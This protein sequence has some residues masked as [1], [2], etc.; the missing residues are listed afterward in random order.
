M[1]FSRYWGVFVDGFIKFG[2]PVVSWYHSMGENVFLN[3]MAEDAQGIE[4]VANCA[5]APFQYVFA[6]HTA[7]KVEEISHNGSVGEIFYKIEQRFDY[8]DDQMWFKTGVCALSLPITLPLGVFLKSLAYLSE[9]VRERHD[10]IIASSLS[11]KVNPHARYYH[12]IGLLTD[13][14]EELNSEIYAR[15]P[16]DENNMKVDKEALKEI[17]RLL[18]ENEIPFW[19]DCGT[20]L[21][22]YRYRGIIPWDFD[23]DIAVLQMDHQNVKHALNA[24]DSDKYQLQDWSSRDKPG[25]YLRLYVKETRNVIDIYHF[26][27]DP[28]TQMMRSICSNIDSAFLPES[29]KTR[30]RRFTIPTPMSDVFPLGKATFD[31]I[32]VFVPNRTKE[33]LQARYGEDISPAKVYDERTGAYEK[34]P[35]HCYW[36]QA[37]AH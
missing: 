2:L 13:G 22:A 32:E 35:G 31:G 30:E 27:I 14:L 9:D 10:L 34:V 11:T 28:K 37:Y 1:D 24:L 17:V 36:K 4:W 15:R 12:S 19:L 21:G 20:C 23:I 33:Y 6:G 26:E 29:W 25:T 5:L 7:I 8:N 16:G 18:K 3:T